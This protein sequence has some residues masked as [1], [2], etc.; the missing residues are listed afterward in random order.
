MTWQ[1][2]L[3]V[4]AA[5]FGALIVW[6]NRPSLGPR[7]VGKARRQALADAR[8]RLAAAT[9]PAE[10]ARALCDAGDASA[11]AV[12]SVTSALGYY[13]RAMRADPT[14]S[15]PVVRTA[16][17]LARRPRTLESVLWRRLGGSGWEGAGRA[18]ALAAL[19]E[20]ARIYAGPLRNR[21]RARAIGYALAA[22]GQAPEP[23]GDRL[24]QEPAPVA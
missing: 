7:K 3:A 19:T 20:L 24:P 15:E 1:L 17:G 13:L 23:S 21:N 4:A 2:A 12:G 8:A 10:R 5:L 22:L 9:S 18:A 6:Q 11:F 14:S 16:R